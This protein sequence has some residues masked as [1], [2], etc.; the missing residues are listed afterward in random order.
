MMRVFL[1][2]IVSL[3]SPTA[4]FSQIAAPAPSA[5]S[6]SNSAPGAVAVST[7]PSDPGAILALGTKM[8]GLDGLGVKP[9]HIKFTYQTFNSDGDPESSGTYEEFWV[10]D[11]IYKRSYTGDSF[12]Q[13]DFGTAHGLYRSGNQNWPELREMKMRAAL[14][15]PML[16]NANLSEVNL[17]MSDR[18]FDQVQL[19]CV[20]LKPKANRILKTMNAPP[21]YPYIHYCFDRKHPIL[22]FDSK[23]IGLDDTLY[24]NITVFQG[25]YVARDVHLVSARKPVFNLHVETLEE[26]AAMSEASFAPLPGAVGPIGGKVTLPASVAQSLALSH[27]SAEYFF[28]AGRAHAYGTAVVQTTIGKNGH[29]TS[30]SGTTGPKELQR[31]AVECIRHQEFRPFLVQ[32]E[33]VEVESN[34]GMSLMGNQ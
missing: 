15:Q 7:L 10:S 26:L 4:L 28:S 31:A 21:S 2:V 12:T 13:T 29:V 16:N 34:I 32:G 8:N 11:K 19:Q 3:L 25:H 5:Q 20:A 6:A 9:W 23:G 27:C 1:L 14:I 18:S 33:A 17:E 22:R 30:A 24:N